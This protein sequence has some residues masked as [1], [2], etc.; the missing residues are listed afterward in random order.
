MCEKEFA[1]A[2]SAGGTA[3]LEA[4]AKFVHNYKFWR[5]LWNQTG[6]KPVGVEFVVKLLCQ[7]TNGTTS[8]GFH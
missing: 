4:H 3:R 5:D 2:A 7:L 6:E 1:A 8:K